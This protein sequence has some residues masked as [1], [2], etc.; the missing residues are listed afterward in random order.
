[1]KF[2]LVEVSM[3]LD[4]I[5]QSVT[6]CM[7]RICIFLWINANIGMHLFVALNHMTRYIKWPLTLWSMAVEYYLHNNQQQIHESCFVLASTSF[8]PG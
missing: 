7:A 4:T 3:G 1:M 5:Q 6:V 2:V 8:T